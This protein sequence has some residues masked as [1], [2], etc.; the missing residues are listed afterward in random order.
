[1]LSVLTFVV[2][3]IELNIFELAVLAGLCLIFIGTV[4]TTIGKLIPG[5][6][7]FDILGEIFTKAGKKIQSIMAGKFIQTTKTILKKKKKL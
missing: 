1:M 6:D 3:G 5:K 7:P 2:L 4:F